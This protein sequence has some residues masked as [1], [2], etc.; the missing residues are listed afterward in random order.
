ME[1]GLPC[2]KV[3]HQPL[4]QNS[5]SLRPK[6]RGEGI[7]KTKNEMGGRIEEERWQ[8]LDQ[9]CKTPRRLEGP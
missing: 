8:H 3:K 4:D 1:M 6:R 7:R 2:S 9:N 5:N